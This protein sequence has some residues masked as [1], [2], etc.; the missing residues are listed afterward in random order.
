MT[1]RKAAFNALN[2]VAQGG[3]STLVLDSILSRSGLD[4]RD[5]ALA[6]AIFYGVLENEQLLDYVILNH[7]SKANSRIDNRL[8]IILRMGVYQIMLMD[9]IPDNAAVNEAVKLT[10][11]IGLKR[12]SGLVNAVLRSFIRAG[13]SCQ[14]PDRVDF[15]QLYLSLKYSVPLWLAEKWIDD[16]GDEMC[17]KILKKLSGRPPIYIR[18]NNLKTDFESL[19]ASL[20]ENSVKINDLTWLGGA[21][22]L[23]DTG[24]IE[25]L[26]AYKNGLF[27]VQDAASQLC[28]RLLEAESGDTV[29][30]VCAAPGGKSFTLTQIMGD[31]G[32]VFSYDIYPQKVSLI[33]S[34]AKRLGLKSLTAKLRDAATGSCDVLAD[35]VLCDVPCSGL[36]IIRR[37]PDIKNKQK[38]DIADLPKL[39]LSILDNSADL[40]KPGGVLVYSTCTLSHDE[41]RNVVES[42]LSKHTDFEPYPFEAPCERGEWD[43]DHM[44][45]LF[46]HLLGTDGFFIARL[47]KKGA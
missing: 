19:K 13:K 47:K 16:Y 35:R 32:S 27:H 20:A 44:L 41:N 2:K 26:E 37:K 1:A 33:E 31:C 15:P 7:L 23:F 9:K 12:A 17:E 30:D 28:C 8:I 18:I 4:K 40:L 38:S 3:Y 34:G 14:L 46:P 29:C 45:T 21:G 6:S 36:G 42:F 43:S 24:D 5:S 10:K 22:E 25:Q 39:Q 11:S